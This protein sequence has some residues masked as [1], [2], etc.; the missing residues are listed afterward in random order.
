MAKAFLKVIGVVFLSGALLLG[1]LYV[2]Q[3]RVLFP[4]RSLTPGELAALLARYPGVQ[5]V[6]VEAPDG[7][8]LHGWYLPAEGPGRQPLVI[9]YGGNGS[10]AVDLLPF[11]HNFAGRSLLVMDYRGYGVNKGKPREDLLYSDALLVFDHFAGRDD[12]DG[13]RIFLVGFSLG[14][15]V[16]TRVAAHR[17]VGAVVLA[18]PFTSVTDIITERLPTLPARRLIRNPMNAAASAPH[19]RAPLLA[20]LADE[21]QVVP[22]RHSRALVQLW[23]SDSRIQIIKDRGH[24]DMH[25]DPVFW[26]SVNRFLDGI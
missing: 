4:A 13:E 8:E 18:A 10:L 20:L 23:G 19:A 16:A 9:Y 21:D 17:P 25:L 3:D 1:A 6:V 26:D 12:V 14:T 5:R 15:A 11:A 2:L 24:N 22:N 7:I